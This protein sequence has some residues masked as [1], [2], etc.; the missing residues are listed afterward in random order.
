L[1][2]YL[3]A[4][5]RILESDDL[6]DFTLS[7]NNRAALSRAIFAE[8]LDAGR[9]AMAV[10]FGEKNPEILDTAMHAKLRTAVKQTGD[11]E[12]A[13]AW[14]ERRLS[15]HG[16]ESLALALMLFDRA[17]TE[18][19][20]LQ[21]EPALARLQRAHELQPGL[22]KIAERLAELRLER[23]ESKAAAKVLNT[24]ISVATDSAEK[25]KARQVLSRIPIK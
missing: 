24:F 14:L 21:V 9:I 22:W 16:E 19:A 7:R 20:S 8:H 2:E 4:S 25:D 23:K 10:T 6:S 1:I 3:K 13:Q 5:G 18:L 17:E 15:Q 11:F 12:A